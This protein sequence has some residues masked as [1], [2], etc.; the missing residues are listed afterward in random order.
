MSRVSE[1]ELLDLWE[2]G[3]SATPFA[4]SSALLALAA[5]EADTAALER[6]PLGERERRLLGFRRH[7]F[8]RQMSAI[9]ICPSCGE[10]HEVD[11]DVDLV[12]DSAKEAPP[13]QLE[14]RDGNTVLRLRLLTG[15]DLKTAAAAPDHASML[16]SL[17]VVDAHEGEH[18]VPVESLPSSSRAAVAAALSEADPL[19]DVM[20]VL[21]CQACRCEWTQPLDTAAYL[22]LELEAW[23]RRML[24]DVHALARAYGWTEAETLHLSPWRRRAYI[25]L[26]SH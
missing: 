19:A 13:A 20:F 12:L 1:R 16:F 17:C 6:L 11:L 5:P 26:A 15:A 4:R 22:W 18:A 21:S 23:A 10:R 3:L 2:R 25:A 14:A 7:L 9:A 8:G 24:R